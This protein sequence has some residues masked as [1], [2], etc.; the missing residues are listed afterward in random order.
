MSNRKRHQG[1]R[2]R[3][4]KG[5]ERGGNEKERGFRERCVWKLKLIRTGKSMGL[6]LLYICPA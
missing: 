5:R 4:E 3:R 2:V 6:V 1:N